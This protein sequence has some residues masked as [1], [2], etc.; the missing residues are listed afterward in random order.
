MV[1]SGDTNNIQERGRYYRWSFP[2]VF[3]TEK[4]WSGFQ[5]KLNQEEETDDQIS[6]VLDYYNYIYDYD[7]Y[8]DDI[9]PQYS[10]QEEVELQ[11]KSDDQL[12]QFTPIDSGNPVLAYDDK[13]YK[14]NFEAPLQDLSGGFVLPPV[15]E[16]FYNSDKKDLKERQRGKKSLVSPLDDQ[17]TPTKMVHFNQL[18]VPSRRIQVSDSPFIFFGNCILFFRNQRG[19]QFLAFEMKAI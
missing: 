13:Y 15:E 9:T 12:Y 7:Y 1:F 10:N 3:S 16:L 19:D 6:N 8:P 18:F 5:W 14:T 17:H 4:Y 2:E 11:N